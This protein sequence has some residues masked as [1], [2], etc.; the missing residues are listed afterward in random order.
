MWNETEFINRFRL[1]KGTVTQLLEKIEHMLVPHIV[2][3]NPISPM[4]QLL[5]TLRFYACDSFYLTIGDFGSVHKSTAGKIINKVT[6]AIARPR[7]INLPN[8]PDAI[9]NEQ[10][11]FFNISRFPR[12][13][14][15][16][17]GTHVRI[18]SPS[19]NNAEVY[20][21]R[22]G[23]FS[24][25]VQV[26]ANAEHKILDIVARW[27]GSAHDSN[28]FDHSN[29]KFKFEN[30]E[31]G[32]GVLLGDSGY[33]LRKYLLT[34]L[35][36]PQTQAENLYNESHI[37]TRNV[38]ERTFGIWKRRFPILSMEIRSEIT[39]AQN[40][41]AVAVLQNIACEQ[42]DRMPEEI[43]DV[44]INEEHNIPMLEMIL[45]I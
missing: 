45:I 40:I 32:N 10:Q 39:L 28:I 24:L 2:R 6:L 23:Y 22:K 3:N 27:P 14:G 35:A 5:M 42:N 44:I 15:A 20:R 21:N 18:Q 8:T 13:I 12:V 11:N 4:N 31:M 19:G 34:P 25:N 43:E 17:D 30:G 33:P 26:V 36:N 37:R 38:V 7:F 29:I 9:V 41:V 16:I 1:T